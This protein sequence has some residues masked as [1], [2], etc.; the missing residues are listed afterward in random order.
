MA[1][2]HMIERDEIPEF[3]PDAE[4][5]AQLQQSAEY[6]EHLAWVNAYFVFGARTERTATHWADA[7]D[8]AVYAIR[9][10]LAQASVVLTS[11]EKRHLTNSEEAHLASALFGD[12]YSSYDS[13]RTAQKE[14]DEAAWRK[15]GDDV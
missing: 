11:L 6:Q 2:F 13:A 5:L 15:W 1:T 4:R 9:A 3:P 7:A 10:I 14:A 8:E 12:I